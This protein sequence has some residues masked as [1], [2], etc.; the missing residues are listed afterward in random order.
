[1]AGSIFLVFV[2]LMLFFLYRA[3]R[4]WKER[5]GGRDENYDAF[6]LQKLIAEE[7]A[8]KNPAPASTGTPGSAPAA[9]PAPAPAAP[10]GETRS[11]PAPVLDAAAQEF[12][13]RLKAELP[14]IPLL[15]CVDLLS[16]T[17]RAGTMPPRIAAD[18]VLCKKD[19]SPVVAIFLER[20]P[21]D[22]MLDRAEERLRQMR[23][24]VLRWPAS[25]LPSREEMREKILGPRSA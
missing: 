16:L 23:V 18:F 14:Q 25:Q 3:W 15:V 5:F 24:R 1:M 12:F 13:F 22:P 17:G 7:S 9:A 2:A 20:E 6:E 19:F 8:V 11:R 21:S 4:V 10:P